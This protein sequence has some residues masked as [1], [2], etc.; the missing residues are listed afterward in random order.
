MNLVKDKR[1]F[2]GI[3]GLLVILCLS[4]LASYF[5]N[6]SSELDI[7]KRLCSLS[8]EHPL[9]CDLNGGDVLNSLLKG[10]RIS[11]G[12]S[13]ATVLITFSV[14][15]LI[16]IL[17]GY[18]GGFWDQVFMRFAD[19]IMAFPGILLALFLAAVLGP[20]YTNL[21][22]AMSVTGWVGAARLVRGQTLSLREREHVQAAKA[23]GQSTVMIL[24]RHIS[25]LL[26]A[27]LIIHATFSLSGV[28]I[29]ESS[30]SFLGLGPE[31]G[32]L[33]WGGLLGQ[34]KTVMGQA[35]W[36]TLAPGIAIMITVMSLNFMGDA[37]R[38]Y[39]DPKSIRSS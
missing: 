26:F 37:L 13:F 2:L 18:V 10:G 20:S 23:I 4:F 19:I 6:L 17:T 12:V 24:L 31:S 9:G 15:V 3:I 35:P 36:L 27:P 33:S 38:D 14:G 5:L 7:T 28:I 29:A 32:I 22:I 21:I 8:W 25:P 34:G 1:F 16:G 30:L 39:F 11:L